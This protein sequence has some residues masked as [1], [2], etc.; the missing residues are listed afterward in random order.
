MQLDYHLMFL[1]LINLII[2]KTGFGLSFQNYNSGYSYDGNDNSIGL[3]SC[4]TQ[5]NNGPGVCVHI[6][7]CPNY[8]D[9]ILSQSKPKICHWSGRV[10]VICCPVV[11]PPKQPTPEPE[12][13][14]EKVRR[15]RN[16]SDCGTRVSSSRDRIVGGDVAYEG[17]FPWNVA[18]FI[19]EINGDVVHECGGSIISD[20][21]I[22]T[23]AHCFDNASP[24]NY[25]IG[26]GSNDLT[27]TIKLKVD[28]IKLHPD[29]D[30]YQFYNDIALIKL[31][32]KLTFNETI[33]PIC[34]PFDYAVSQPKSASSQYSETV[35][36][37]GW[38]FT[39]FNGERSRVLL[40]ADLNL[41]P[42]EMC[43]KTYSR[44]AS[45]KISRGIT[46]DFICAGTADGKKDAC[47]S[48]SGGPLIAKLETGDEAEP[49]WESKFVQIG[50]V[51]FGYKCGVRGYPGVY[52]NVQKYLSWIVENI[53]EPSEIMIDQ[54]FNYENIEK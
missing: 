47:Q 38:G 27:S 51:S 45:R 26:V 13:P 23:A 34:L 11:D 25:L 35:T 28:E 54:K 21:Y 12:S 39:E 32:D 24:S 5:P 33:R 9:L 19:R 50:I 49:G 30:K 20:Q 31:T 44:L 7:E 1:N 6:Y 10:P 29:Y 37:S 2:I 42:R 52:V 17:E 22:L 18:I 46:D 3:T 15:Q 36:I 14:I 40:K 4:L 8:K 48:D 43:N 53:R 41:M 16:Q